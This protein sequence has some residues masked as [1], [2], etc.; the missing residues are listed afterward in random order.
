MKKYILILLFCQLV[1]SNLALAIS[2]EYSDFSDATKL[3]LNGTAQSATSNDGDKVLRLTTSDTSPGIS[4]SV[5]Q[6]Q[7]FHINQNTSFETT[8]TFQITEARGLAGGGDGLMF[9]LQSQ[10]EN[11]L[12]TGGGYLGFGQGRPDEPSAI[13]PSLGIEF[14]TYNNENFSGGVSDIFDP[15]NNHVGIDMNGE[16]DSLV[17]ASVP[18]SFKN[19]EIWTAWVDYNGETDFIEVRTSDTQERPTIPLLS[20][21]IDVYSI[22]GESNIFAGFTAGIAGAQ[23]NHDI[24]SWSFYITESTVPA[25]STL[26]LLGFGLIGLASRNLPFSRKCYYNTR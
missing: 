21:N 24:R 18:T 25:P 13:L 22:F 1:S 23:S 5:F 3:T 10:D 2:I 20:Y 16:L 4:G 11:A 19:G 9:V 17:T 7:S 8:F 12:G 6:N 14:D 15:D 26:V